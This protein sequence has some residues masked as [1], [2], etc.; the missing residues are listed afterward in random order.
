MKAILRKGL[1]HPQ[2]PLPEDWQ[3][4][5]EVEVEKR[6]SPQRK[7]R[8]SRADEWMDA[9][10]AAAAQGDPADDARLDAA[11]REVRRRNKELA[12]K[13]AGLDG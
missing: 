4:G 13:K 10:E 11:I 5:T 12:R 8:K 2:E 6:K 3:E 7:S 9:V 1:I